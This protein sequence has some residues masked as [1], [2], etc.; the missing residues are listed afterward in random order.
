MQRFVFL[1]FIQRYQPDPGTTTNVLPSSQ[2]TTLYSPKAT[3][4]YSTNWPTAW[5][6][7]P[8]VRFV[9]CF[10]YTQPGAETNWQI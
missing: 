4:S 6:S 5:T 1:F 2:E 10:L 9:M 8:S 3:A 7:A